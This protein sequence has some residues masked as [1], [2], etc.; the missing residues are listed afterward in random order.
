MASAKRFEYPKGGGMSNII[1]LQREREIKMLIK[2]LGELISIDDETAKRTFEY[3]KQKAEMN[4]SSKSRTVSVR[5]PQELLDWIDEYAR[6][7]AVDNRMRVTRNSVVVNF[8]ETM[9]AVI[10]LRERDEW[11]GKHVDEIKNL[12]N[13]IKQQS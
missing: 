1:S 4:E 5:F 9:R 7:L 10:E 13:T 2:D 6:I 3:L 12:I 8:L 11:H